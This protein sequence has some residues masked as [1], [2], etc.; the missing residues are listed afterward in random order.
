MTTDAP[1]SGFYI[2]PVLGNSSSPCY[3]PGTL[4]L[5]DRGERPVEA[6]AAGDTVVTASGQHRPIRWIGRRSNAGR[7]LA[8]NPTVQ[9]IRFRAGSLEDGLPRR[10]LLVSPE[11]AM[12]IDGLLIP[13]RCLVNGT[14]IVRERGL[15]QVD[16]Y[17]VELNSH[18]VLLAEGAPS[19][20][21]LDD[22]SRGMFHNASEFAALY[23]DGFAPG[24]FCAPKVED[25]YQL[26]AIRRRLA[27]SG[28]VAQ[29]A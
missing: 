3:C 29:A 10:D 6:L 15:D 16:Y 4:I 17:H 5:T 24:E 21:F 8:A 28:E 13:A 14:T 7:F 23:P 9:P 18:D 11:H 26:E 19:E 12:F 2:D 27:A 22:D 20:S 1:N 25:G